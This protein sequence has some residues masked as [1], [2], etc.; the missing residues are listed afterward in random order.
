MSSACL[1]DKF[2]MVIE[3]GNK[4]KI[5]YEGTLDTGEVFD[6]SEGKTPLEIPVG[7]GKV[8]PGFENEI[9]GMKKGEEKTIKI[10][11]EEA[12][13]MPDP[14]KIQKLPRNQLPE[15]IQEK[16]KPGIVLAMQTPEGNK[17]PVKVTDADQ[18][19]ITLD[20]NHPLAGQTLNFKIKVVDVE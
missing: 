14:N 3:K 13:G 12:Y 8:I 20:M 4:V 7:E 9:L 17:V 6:T 10:L 5:E 19:T 2:K 11:P 16:V 15:Q 1:C 18:E